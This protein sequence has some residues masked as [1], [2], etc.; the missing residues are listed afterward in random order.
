M[1]VLLTFDVEEFDTPE[2]YGRK[3]SFEEKIK[4]ST[5]GLQNVLT[6]VE[7]LQVKCTFFTTAVYAL[8]QPELIKIISQSHEIASHGYSHTTFKNSDLKK[9][10][11]TLEA[12]IGKEIQGFRMARMAKVNDVEIVKAGYQYNASLNPTWIPGRY[13]HFFEPRI[14]FKK[15]DLIQIPASVSTIFRIPLFWLSFENFPMGLLKFLVKRA[16]AHD[17]FLSLYFHPW[18]FTNIK[19]TGVPSF[20]SKSSGEIMLQ[21][22]QETITLVRKIESTEFTTINEYINDH[23]HKEHPHEIRH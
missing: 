14:P 20:I 13:F 6:L 22:L 4:I 7:Q 18:E 1:K 17:G 2:E 15:N 11:D 9:S 5:V 10:K 19:N 3:I 21:R 23:F 8:E 12:L 16:L